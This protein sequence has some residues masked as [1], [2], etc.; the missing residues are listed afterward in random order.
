VTPSSTT[1]PLPLLWLVVIGP[2]SPSFAGNQ[3]SSGVAHPAIFPSTLGTLPRPLLLANQAGEQDS[4]L[5]VRASHPVLALSDWGRDIMYDL[6]LACSLHQ[7]GHRYRRVRS[8]VTPKSLNVWWIMDYWTLGFTNNRFTIV[9][10]RD[11]R[12]LGG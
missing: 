5:D 2:P 6:F 4:S 12:L 8:G 10:F 11:V 3:V 7:F 9:D 1:D